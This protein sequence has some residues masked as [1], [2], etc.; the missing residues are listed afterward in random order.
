MD[1]GVPSYT[2]TPLVS[3]KVVR[4]LLVVWNFGPQR[5]TP[6]ASQSFPTHCPYAHS[7]AIGPHGPSVA[8]GGAL[9]GGGQQ[10]ESRL[11]KDIV[12]VIKYQGARCAGTARTAQTARCAR[13]YQTLAVFLLLFL[14]KKAACTAVYR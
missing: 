7:V 13:H 2:L 3:E 6:R 1:P 11:S 8:Q 5:A 12:Y 14:C 9:R 10:I 4:T